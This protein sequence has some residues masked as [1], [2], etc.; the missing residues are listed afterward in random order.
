MVPPKLIHK[1][2]LYN[3]RYNY[4]ESFHH[5]CLRKNFRRTDVYN[6]KEDFIIFLKGQNDPNYSVNL[7]CLLNYNVQLELKCS[8]HLHFEKSDFQTLHYIC[9]N[10]A[11]MHGNMAL[12]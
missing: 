12:N 11:A 8:P 6:I 5:I 10:I 1:M 9:L 4:I 2:A 3:P 7:L